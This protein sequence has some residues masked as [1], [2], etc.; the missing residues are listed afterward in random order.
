MREEKDDSIVTDG[1]YIGIKPDLYADPGKYI[2]MGDRNF[3]LC[4]L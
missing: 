4:F 1:T 3:P 2:L